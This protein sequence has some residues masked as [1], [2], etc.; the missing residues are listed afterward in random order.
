[1]LKNAK[2]TLEKQVYLKSIEID[3]IVTTISG[4]V[5]EIFY[6]WVGGYPYLKSPLYGSASRLPA[7]SSWVKVV[8]DDH[9]PM[10]VH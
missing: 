7:T 8:H 3:V 5:T 4:L 6:G 9:D 1:M 2:P 10:C